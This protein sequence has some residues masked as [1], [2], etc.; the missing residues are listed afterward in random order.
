M[1]GSSMADCK[2][3]GRIRT[4]SYYHVLHHL[5]HCAIYCSKKAKALVFQQLLYKCKRSRGRRLLLERPKSQRNTRSTPVKCFTDDV[6]CGKDK[7]GISDCCQKACIRRSRPAYQT[8]PKGEGE[9]A[10]GMLMPDMCEPR[11]LW[12]TSL[13]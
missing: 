12:G 8:L 9:A 3:G 13:R 10:A 5:E 7:C 6:L 2:E 1:T 4:C 11:L